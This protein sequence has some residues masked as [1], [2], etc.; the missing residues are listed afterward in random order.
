MTTQR[1]KTKSACKHHVCLCLCVRVR[2]CVCVCV[3]VWLVLDTHLV[4]KL[5]WCCVPLHKR[6][7]RP[8]VVRVTHRVRSDQGNNVTVTEPHATKRGSN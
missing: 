1:E 4:V 3:S 2:V 8:I 7:P 6:E 5:E